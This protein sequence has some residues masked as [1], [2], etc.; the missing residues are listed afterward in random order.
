MCEF[1][2]RERDLWY[3]LCFACY[4]QFI[5]KMN[6]DSLYE[7]LLRPGLILNKNEVS[8]N[9]FILI[10]KLFNHNIELTASRGNI[11]I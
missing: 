6:S 9:C 10:S 7:L 3:F 1:N 5:N 11:T 4:N 2:K 8:T